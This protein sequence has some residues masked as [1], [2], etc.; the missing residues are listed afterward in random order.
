MTNE[1][2]MNRVAIIGC[3]GSG[4]STFARALHERTGLPL[5]HLDNLWWKPDRTHITREEFDA[6]LREILDGEAWIVDGNYSRTVEMRIAACD[7][8]IFLDYNEQTCMDG[9]VSRIGCERPDIPWTES[10]LDPELVALVK[11]F[12]T[13]QR[14][15][16]L[17][18]LGR[19]AEGREILIF[20]TRES[21]DSWL[22]TAPQ[23]G[24][25]IDAQSLFTLAMKHIYG[26][27]VPEDNDLAFRLLT[28]AQEMGHTEAT[29]NLGICYHY[30]YGTGVD[31]KQAFALYLQSANAGYGK[32]MELV[33]RFY[34]RGIFVDRD[35]KQAE[36]WLSKAME[37]ADA[38][39]VEEAKKE[40]NYHA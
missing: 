11:G 12:E 21:A 39:A 2:A 22:L 35:R 36:H 23:K 37:S 16:I 26:D 19:Y 32:G 17:A 20:R 33:G 24:G 5:F 18:L 1:G 27:G 31:L 10:E 30:G 6:A 40:W 14:P 29:Y 9:I 15:A 25:N 34:N 8:V 7:T 38:D 4:K 13:E 28:Q 3:P